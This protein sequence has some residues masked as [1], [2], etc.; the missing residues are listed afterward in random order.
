[1]HLANPKPVASRP[2]REDEIARVRRDR[3]PAVG[4][5]PIFSCGIADVIGEHPSKVRL[6]AGHSESEG[7]LSITALTAASCRG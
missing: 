3:L 2:S 1:M 6:G 4:L 5:T 7:S